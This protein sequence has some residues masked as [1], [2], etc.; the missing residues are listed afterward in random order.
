MQPKPGQRLRARYHHLPLCAAEVGAPEQP[1]L[2]ALHVAFRTTPSFQ[3]RPS[4]QSL[5]QHLTCR[6]NSLAQSPQLHCRERLAGLLGRQS[7][8][9][10]SRLSAFGCCSHSY[11]TGRLTSSLSRTPER[12]GSVAATVHRKQAAQLLL[13]EAWPQRQLARAEDHHTQLLRRGRLPQLSRQQRLHPVPHTQVS[14][15]DPGC[16]TSAHQSIVEHWIFIH[17]G[18]CDCDR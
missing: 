17:A 18:V 8:R 10:C 11:S 2:T 5:P 12:S 15:P 4:F 13:G 7:Q 3:A 6:H 1:V 14:R 16:H 9:C